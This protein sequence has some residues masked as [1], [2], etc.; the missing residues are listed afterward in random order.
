MNEKS[1]FCIVLSKW[2]WIAKWIE[3]HLQHQG[4]HLNSSLYTSSH[5]IVKNEIKHG[6]NHAFAPNLLYKDLYT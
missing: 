6:Q 5:S 2:Q 4:L 3:L 1:Q